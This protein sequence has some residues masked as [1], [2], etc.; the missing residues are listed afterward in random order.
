MEKAVRLHSRIE[1]KAIDL[2]KLVPQ[3]LKDQTSEGC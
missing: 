2:S 3:I 1:I